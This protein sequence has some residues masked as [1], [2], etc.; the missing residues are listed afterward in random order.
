MPQFHS[1]SYLFIEVD[2]IAFSHFHVMQNQ[3]QKHH[4]FLCHSVYQVLVVTWFGGMWHYSIVPVREQLVDSSSPV[5]QA[6]L[7]ADKDPE[8]RE[9]GRRSSSAQSKT[10]QALVQLTGT[11]SGMCPVLI[12]ILKVLC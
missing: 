3:S 11:E 12:A 4:Q 10:F 8:Q 7:T 9:W 2:F 1:H 5:C 6:V